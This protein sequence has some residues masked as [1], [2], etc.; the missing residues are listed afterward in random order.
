MFYFYYFCSSF[1]IFFSIF[2]FIFAV[3]EPGVFL[4]RFSDSKPGQIAISYT[5][6]EII[7]KINCNNSKEKKKLIV[8]HCLVDYDKDGLSLS[9][10]NDIRKYETL[11]ILLID[12]KKLKYFY[13]YIHKSDAFDIVDRFQVNSDAI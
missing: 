8:G 13:P 3:T 2:Q 11:K 5:D 9:L 4:L 1:Y 6:Y 12:C 10:A 7:D